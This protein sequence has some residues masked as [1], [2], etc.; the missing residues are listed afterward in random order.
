MIYT[1]DPV[2]DAEAYQNELEEREAARD[3]IVCDLCGG[4]IYKE[5]G[6]YEGDQYWLFE[7]AIVCEKCLDNYLSGK[8]RTAK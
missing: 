4:K 2:R 5:E 3:Y 1:G 6:I 8:R 7:D